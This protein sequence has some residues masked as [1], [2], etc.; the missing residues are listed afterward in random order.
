MVLEPVF[1]TVQSIHSLSVM[2]SSVLAFQTNIR[3]YK[4]LAPLVYCLVK[5]ESTRNDFFLGASCL[6][7]AFCHPRVNHEL[8]GIL[9]VLWTNSW[10]QAWREGGKKFFRCPGNC[11]IM[12][13]DKSQ[14][15]QK[16]GEKKKK[17]ERTPQSKRLQWITLFSKTTWEQT[18]LSWDYF[19]P[20]RDHK[21]EAISS[22][23]SSALG[24][25]PD[26]W[27]VFM[28]G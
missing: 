19:L 18:L 23:A 24:L 7:L 14:Q 15:T 16:A 10:K 22:T 20:S 28:Y 21:E 6:S 1:Y 25:L 26:N 3:K 9:E 13:G 12:R 2:Q 17:E 27:K 4:M 8:W 11:E 5:S